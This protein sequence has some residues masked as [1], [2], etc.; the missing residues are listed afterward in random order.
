MFGKKN[1]KKTRCKTRNGGWC[2]PVT[3]AFQRLRQ[4]DQEFWIIRF[5]PAWATWNFVSNKRKEEISVLHTHTRQAVFSHMKRAEQ[6]GS[7]TERTQK[8]AHRNIISNNCLHLKTSAQANKENKEFVPSAIKMHRIRQERQFYR[9]SVTFPYIWRE[10]V[11][12]QK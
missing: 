8:W 11:E 12:K 6:Y 4:E 2:L 7:N 10:T 5:R 3:S 9:I 1:W